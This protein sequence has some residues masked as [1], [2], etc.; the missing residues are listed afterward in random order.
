MESLTSAFHSFPAPEKKLG[1]GTA[2]F[3]DN[4][5]LPLHSVFVRMGILAC[6]RSMSVGSKPVGVMITASHNPECDN[7]IKIVDHDGGMLEQ[8]WEPFAE[9]LANSKTLEDF[10]AVLVSIVKA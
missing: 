4:A 2:G 5:A 3:R 9:S 8:S 1:Y 7:G 10:L 6:F